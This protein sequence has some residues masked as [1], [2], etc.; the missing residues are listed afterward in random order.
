MKISCKIIED[1]LPLYCDGVCS[2]DS[3]S[4]VDKHLGECEHCKNIFNSMTDS[5][6]TNRSKEIEKLKSV[7]KKWYETR[8]KSIIKGLILG[9]SICLIAIL[10]FLGLTQWTVLPVSTDKMI[11]SDIYELK[12]NEIAFHLYI[13]DKLDLNAVMVD[14]TDDGDM[15][16][17]PKRNII[18][19]RRLKDFNKG[20]YNR[21]YVI[22]TQG[23]IKGY[24]DFNYVDEPLTSIYIGTEK[25][26]IL[27]WDKNTEIKKADE[28]IQKRF[29]DSIN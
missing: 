28:D 7:S 11:I 5:P 2:Q 10:V 17:T 13:D 22:C 15:Y 1:L 19:N 16:I 27:I 6:E 25:D 8:K 9:I 26:N 3:K 14:I 18:E 4:L 21:D 20:L 24:A 23:E 12:N 29:T